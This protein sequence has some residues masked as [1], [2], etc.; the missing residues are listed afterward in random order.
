MFFFTIYLF[1]SPFQ[2]IQGTLWLGIV[3]L[4]II[5]IT[6]G[7]FIFLFAKGLTAVHDFLLEFIID[8]CDNPEFYLTLEFISFLKKIRYKPHNYYNTVK[9][10]KEDNVNQYNFY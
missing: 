6:Y 8:L 10:S 7:G 3:L 2:M 9:N 5:L 4:P 1:S